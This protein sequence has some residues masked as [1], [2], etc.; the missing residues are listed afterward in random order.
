MEDSKLVVTESARQ[1]INDVLARGNAEITDIR[2]VGVIGYETAQVNDSDITPENIRKGVNILGVDGTFD[3]DGGDV[4]PAQNGIQ[5]TIEGTNT[6]ESTLNTLVD[7][8]DGKIVDIYVKDDT[9]KI[10][11]RESILENKNHL[12][13]K[14]N[15]HEVTA[16]QVGSYSK[17]EI[18]DILVSISNEVAAISSS[19]N[20]HKSDKNNPHQVTAQQLKVYTK[21]EV[22]G[23]ING[24]VTRLEA[25]EAT[26]GNINTVLESL[27]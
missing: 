15:P 19:I 1:I 7:I 3:G 16:N 23:I 10:N 17:S 11:V 25:I 2:P 9:S 12:L 8:Q 22:D 6:Q 14:N 13:N 5:G 4:D 18:D 24:L 21:S 27:L 26:I 20:S